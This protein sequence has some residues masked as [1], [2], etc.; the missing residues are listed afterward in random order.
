MFVG[1]FPCS[2]CIIVKVRSIGN[3]QEL[4]LHVLHLRSAA[5]LVDV[6]RWSSYVTETVS[7]AY[8][9]TRLIFRAEFSGSLVYRLHYREALL[10]MHCMRM[11]FI[12]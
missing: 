2:S 8:Q 9:T 10:V 11:V 1:P 12:L 5:Q 7:T 4:G 3:D 6:M